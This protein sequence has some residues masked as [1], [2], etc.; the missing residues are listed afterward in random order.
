MAF[1]VKWET[2]QREPRAVIMSSPDLYLESKSWSRQGLGAAASEPCFVASP[3]ARVSP[4]AHF[5]AR[6]RLLDTATVLAQDRF[7]ENTC[8]LKISA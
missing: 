6:N 5:S 2:C 4:S 1:S 8:E 3:P 7:L